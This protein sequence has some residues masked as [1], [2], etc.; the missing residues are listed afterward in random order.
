[1][2]GPKGEPARGNGRRKRRYQAALATDGSTS[3]GGCPRALQWL[4]PRQRAEVEHHVLRVLTSNELPIAENRVEAALC[5]LEAA[6]SALLVFERLT[7]MAS[8]RVPITKL[9]A[10]RPLSAPPSYSVSHLVRSYATTTQSS[11]S[12]GGKSKTTPSRRQ[13]TVVNDDGHIRWRDL[14]VREKTARTTQQSF[15]FLIVL[16]GIIMTVRSCST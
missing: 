5:K 3:G 14:S 12:G 6:L 10:L 11:S 8:L 15:N 4:I 13:V 1:M 7:A 2:S 9:C 16:T